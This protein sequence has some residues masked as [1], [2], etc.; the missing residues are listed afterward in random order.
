MARDGSPT[1]SRIVVV[2]RRVCWVKGRTEV[3]VGGPTP[4]RHKPEVLAQPTVLRQGSTRDRR[5]AVRASRMLA[6]IAAALVAALLSL[7]GASLVT[8]GQPQGNDNGRL[9]TAETATE[10]A[11]ATGREHA[12]TRASG[13]RRVRWQ[14]QSQARARGRPRT[15]RLGAAVAAPSRSRLRS[16]RRRVERRRQQLDR[17]VRTRQLEPGL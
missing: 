14:R 3:A 6:A 12:G 1:R 11:T 8:A 15:E 16:P 13:A 10:T 2:Q 9:T 5:S 7:G 4:G 17:H